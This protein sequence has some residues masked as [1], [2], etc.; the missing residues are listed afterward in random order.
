MARTPAGSNPPH[1][2]PAV[3]ATAV[4]C[5]LLGSACSGPDDDHDTSTATQGVT[6]YA[7]LTLPA[8]VACS[9]TIVEGQVVKVADGDGGRMVTTLKVT[10][11]LR[12]ARGPNQAEID[13]VDIAGATNAARPTVG[14]HVLVSVFEDRD[15]VPLIYTDPKIF[16]TWEAA[17]PAGIQ[18]NCPV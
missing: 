16:D 10:K 1:K 2:H 13:T 5:L 12:P 8:T 9:T 4:A 17:I 14:S 3:L 11:W 18:R 7:E 15:A 6:D